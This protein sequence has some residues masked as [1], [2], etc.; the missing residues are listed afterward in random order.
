MKLL[1]INSI[2]VFIL[3]LFAGCSHPYCL[4][5]QYVVKLKPGAEGKDLAISSYGGIFGEI[6]F[7]D[8]PFLT[9][10]Y[11]TDGLQIYID[12]CYI[13]FDLYKIPEGAKINKAILTLYADTS[14]PGFNICL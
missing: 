14:A 11:E 13:D 4:I 12:Y 5:E 6:N 9:G 8:D 3:F 10:Y 2:I 1:S 7:G